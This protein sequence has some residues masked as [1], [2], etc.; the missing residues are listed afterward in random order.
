[1]KVVFVGP[2]L[3]DA[4]ARAGDAVDVR[5]PAR[6]GDVMKALEEGASAIGLI[7][8]FFEMVAPVWH[9]ELLFALSRDV[10]VLGAAS[11][12]ALRAAECAPFGMLGIGRIFNDYASGARVDDADVALLH[13]PAE[14]GYPSLTVPIVNLDATLDNA[15][16]L[17]LLD[18]LQAARLAE[19]G[20]SLF[21][22]N[23][24]W[25]SIASA[26]GFDINW[27][28]AIVGRGFVDQKQ[29]DACLLLDKLSRIGGAVQSQREWTFHAT[30][31]WRRLYPVLPSK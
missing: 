25:K 23:R 20:R 13:G 5:P 17:D 3:P 16:R 24:T 28:R 2:S 8:G 22:K 14:L 9:K 27:L 30:P 15:L 6:Q 18:P 10:P 4:A 1:M 19:A 12:G 21:Y 11:M 31:L 7:D 26:S 29:V